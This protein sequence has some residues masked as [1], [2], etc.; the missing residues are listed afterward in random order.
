MMLWA[1]ALRH[2]VKRGNLEMCDAHGKTYPIGDG[3]GALIRIALHDRRLHWQLV[4]NPGLYL[5]QAYMDKTL[6]VEQ[7]TIGDF[8]ALLTSNI[9]KLPEHWLTK[10]TDKLDGL[11]RLMQQYNPVQKAAKNVQHH[12]DLSDEL[13]TRF[14]DKDMQYSCA[15]FTHE[16][17]SL[18]DAQIAK[19]HHIA[20]KLAL[21]P[22]MK[23]L[24]IGC[25]WGGMAMTLAKDYGV[26]VTGLTLSHEQHAKA[27]ERIRS[28]G[29][30]DKIQFKL[31]DY[32][33]ETGMYDRIVSVGMFE[34]VGVNH[35]KEIF[36]KIKNL[37]KQDGVALLHSIGRMDIPGTT[38]PW[39]RKYIFPGGYSPA[40]SE[41]MPVIEK[42]GLW[43]NDIEILR[44]HYALT[45]AEWNQR[46]Q[47]CRTEIV[48][49]YDE[50][51]CR[52]WEFFLFACEME[53]R[54]LR[55]MVFQIQIT[56]TSHIL[57]ITRDY[58]NAKE[59][60]MMQGAKGIYAAA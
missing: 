50:R 10:Y 43:A 39:L 22:G 9:A 2:V 7:G 44:M 17:Q 29:L 37:L 48:G 11:T 16:G 55:A 42:S 1:R 32:R 25:G 28:A 59:A 31:C 21:K 35:Y 52:M 41:V 13:Y 45:L 30:A 15:Y 57:P 3:S 58:M 6:T 18:E 4:M 56:H 27:S 24:D 12:Y 51:F 14:L 33:H 19:K 8:L 26:H 49:I 54:Y 23:V 36:E 20:A 5:G 40:L 47:A 53:F 46:F 38:Y 34:H 60:A